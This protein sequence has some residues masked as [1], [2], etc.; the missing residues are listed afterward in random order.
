MLVPGAARAADTL[1]IIGVMMEFQEDAYG[2]NTTG[3]GTFD[4][5]SN[6]AL[7]NQ[8]HDK[9]YFE[10]QLEFA[11]NYFLFASDSHLIIRYAVYDA[12]QGPQNHLT[13]GAKM[14]HYRIPQ[15][16]D[17]ESY[18]EFNLRLNQGIMT[19]AM[20]ALK[21]AAS[22]GILDIGAVVRTTWGDSITVDSA[23]RFLVFHAGATQLTDGGELGSLGVNSPSDF[24]DSYIAPVDFTDYHGMAYDD[25]ESVTTLAFDLKDG[26]RGVWSADSSN[27]VRELLICSETASQDGLNWGIHGIFINQIGRSLGLPDLWNTKDGTTAVGGFCLMDVA[28]YNTFRGFLP[29][30]PS[31][32]CRVKLGWVNPVIAEPDSTFRSVYTIQSMFSGRGSNEIIKVPLSATEY[33]LVEN[34]QF[35]PHGTDSLAI[36]TDLNAGTDYRYGVYDTVNGAY[37]E[38]FLD[39]LCNDP[40][41][42]GTR[43]NT[44]KARGRVISSSSYDMGLPGFGVLLWHVDEK[45]LR[46]NLAIN[47]VNANMDR[48]GV[49]LV[50]ADGIEDIGVALSNLIQTIYLYG[51]PEDFYPHRD[52]DQGVFVNSIT[53]YEQRNRFYGTH[54]NAG[55]YTG[56]TIT[57][58]TIA[59]K[60]AQHR[61]LNTAAYELG[62]EK[63]IGVYAADSFRITVSWALSQGKWPR[64]VDTNTVAGHPVDI[65]GR[66]YVTTDSGVIVSYKYNGDSLLLDTLPARRLTSPSVAWDSMLVFGGIL[67]GKDT[68]AVFRHNLNSDTILLK[69]GQDTLS[70]LISVVRDTLLFGTR[71]GVI[72]KT[73]SGFDSAVSL[74]N[75]PVQALACDSLRIYAFCAGRLFKISRL[76]LKVLEE[77]SV[78]GLSGSEV[79]LSGGDV[80]QSRPGVE[81]VLCDNAGN[82][83]LLDSS[84]NMLPGWP[85]RIENSLAKTPSLGDVDGDGSLDIV[86]PGD[87]KI[88][89]VSYNATHLT[90]WPLIVARRDNVG[91]IA[92]TAALFDIDGN[93]DMEMFVPLPNGNIIVLDGDARTYEFTAGAKVLSRALSFGGRPGPSCVVRNIDTDRNAASN[94]PEH[95]EIYTMSGEG[96]L[97]CFNIPV[98]GDCKA[99]WEAEGGSLAR[100]CMY[101]GARP[102]GPSLASKLAV[103]TLFT[104]PNPARGMSDITIKYRLSRDASEVS[105][106]M[107][108][109]AGDLVMEKKGLPA[110]PLW[111]HHPLD[112][113]KIAPGMYT[114]KLTAKGASG[115]AFKFTKVGVIR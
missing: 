41:C 27:L 64:Y 30:L 4:S 110:Y 86:V 16:R 39:S 111:N 108:N 32:W 29:V 9:A 65:N 49:D 20:D 37:V 25:D 80:W 63:H 57:V 52:I 14:K 24:I 85:M 88:Y 54:T 40:K 26:R 95:V 87:N 28:G 79:R 55:G 75:G 48:R 21:K 31:A 51:G 99:G 97:S 45:V 96:Y 8:R 109:P 100:S 73:A 50:E 59:G 70:T 43:G 1:K 82:L 35:L 34:R 71:H 68:S 112:I 60:A 67:S 77:K 15:K 23:T 101:S 33:F 42:E 81:L 94:V 58:D 104:W 106:K 115:T 113:R 72:H 107:F 98:S 91:P 103:D 90:H 102:S 47:M 83:A 93:H 61:Y 6:Y 19:F 5:D 105:M 92:S 18:D 74:A 17:K 53:P 11:R 12:P 56:I 44:R 7:D 36:R 76:T 46:D 84:L 114:L 38:M 3:L 10:R 22:A 89:A 62:Q 66:L 2:D 13:L 69:L 78:P